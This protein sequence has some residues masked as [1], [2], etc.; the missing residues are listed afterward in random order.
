[1]KK[2]NLLWMIAMAICCAVLTFG[3]AGCGS[4][5]DDGEAAEPETTEAVQEETAAVEAWYDSVIND[6]SVTQEFP[7]YRLIDIDQDGTEELFL[8]STE[9]AFIGAEDKAKLIASVDGET[10]TVKEI[11]GA[12][13]ESFSYDEVDKSL[14]YYSR[15][16]GEEHIIKYKYENGE[17]TE[18]QTADE[19]DQNHDPET[20]NNPV[21]TYYL[22]G[23]KVTE[24]EADVLW[25]QFDDQAY[26]I[27]YSADG[28]GNPYVDDDADEPED[29]DDG[30]DQY[31]D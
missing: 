31:D 13:G 12:G 28:Q 11:G 9:K 22:D 8:S 21:D 16:S 10:V 7:Y 6:P 26:A 5:D 23:K 17:L 29:G 1:M 27:T 30:D 14:F 18:L 15:L 24:H 2:K 3:L 4:S 19:Y 20:G 25:D